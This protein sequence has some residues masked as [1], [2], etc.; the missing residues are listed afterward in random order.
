MF[1]LEL[2]ISGVAVQS[3]HQNSEKWQLLQ[4]I[5]QWKWNWDCFNHSLLLW[6][7]CQGLW[8]T[9]EDC[10]KSKGISQMILVCCNLLNSQNIPSY[11]SV[12]WQWKMVGYKDTPNIA[13]KNCWSCTE[14]SAITGLLRVL[15]LTEVRLL[16]TSMTIGWGITSKP[17]STKSKTKAI[18]LR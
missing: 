13:K 3:I 17:K 9:S 6:S 16:I 15:S 11:E 4:G 5:A 2:E 14:K 18:F 8:S 10:C 1:S 12:K 7:W